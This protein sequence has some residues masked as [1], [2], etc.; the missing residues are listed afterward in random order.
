MGKVSKARTVAPKQGGY[1]RSGK[2]RDGIV[3]LKP[4]VKSRRFTAEEVRR[5]I[6]AL[7]A[8]ANDG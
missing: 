4:V 1:Q 8:G 5:T 6:A 7:R 2:T 3:I